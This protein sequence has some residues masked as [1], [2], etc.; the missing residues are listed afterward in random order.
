MCQIDKRV[1]RKYLRGGRVVKVMTLVGER[2]EAGD[3][4]TAGVIYSGAQRSVRASS[5]GYWR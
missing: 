4:Q 1:V 5:S 2:L 3:G